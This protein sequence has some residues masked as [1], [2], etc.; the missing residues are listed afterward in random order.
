[1]H[2]IS[3]VAIL[4]W[5]GLGAD[6]LSSSAYGPDEAWRALG[7]HHEL[8]IFLAAATALTVFI[9]SYTYSRTI[10]HFPS[11][12]G[13]YAVASQ[14]LGAPL[15]AVSGGALLIDYVLTIAVSITSGADQLFSFLPLA[16]HSMKLPVV[17]LALAGLVLV[18]LRGVKESISLLMPVFLLFLGCHAAML[19]GLFAGHAGT[20]AATARETSSAISSGMGSIGAWGMFLIL[21][22]AYAQG[23]GTYTGIEA[24]ANGI[25]IMREPRV[26]TAKRTMLYMA[27]SLAV[28]AGGIL[29]GYML[30]R[31]SVQEG[32]TLNAVLLQSLGWG[33][34]FVVLTLISEAA[35]LLVA[36]QTGFVGGPR[37]MSNMALDSWLPHRFTSLSERLVLHDG[38]LLIGGAALATILYARGNITT[39]VTMYSINV[40]ITFT[41][42][43]LGMVRFSVRE[44][45]R[46]P[47][48]MR[49]LPIH[50]TG[51]VLCI[52]ILSILVYE[53]FSEGAWLTLVLTFLLVVLCFMIR[54]YYRQVRKKFIQLAQ[55]LE[56]IPAEPGAAKAKTTLNP[57]EPVAALLVGSYGGLGL[58]SILAIQRLF[59]HYYKQMVFIS[60]AVIDSGHFKGVRE[61]DEL[62]AQTER[63]LKKYVAMANRLAL[64]AT[65]LMEVGT[66]PVDE[67]E[68]LCAKAA[69]KYP[70]ITFFA[71]QLIFQKEV[72]Y[73]RILHNDTAF[74]IQRR[75][76]WRGLP[77]LI[78]PIRA[79]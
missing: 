67:A 74:A 5:V 51:L 27:I 46:T 68:Q 53:K 54:R 14:L 23:A 33:Q 9:I 31:V 72:W 21:A 52:G 3:L 36:A 56:E 45:R 78:L 19:L 41:L 42:T 63:T 13:G 6:G 37:V 62:K 66:D 76:Q 4:A 1:Y 22:R 70:F 32:K 49:A 69:K 55:Q 10:E 26:A 44:R 75:L 40:F 38:V 58:H 29:L 71:G 77:M 35:L 34:W 73:Q 8:A 60:V 50:I 7:G 65:L 64:D 16:T 25:P 57:E 47:G 11:G 18:N 17:I 48:V 12:G 24:V 39:L 28:T 59:P 20:I 79:R 30:L 61:V 15:G 43:E 2:K